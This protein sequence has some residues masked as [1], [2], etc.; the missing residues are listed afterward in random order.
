MSYVGLAVDP[1]YREAPEDA[2]RRGAF[3]SVVRAAGEPE[4]FEMVERDRDLVVSLETA[5]SGARIDLKRDGTVVSSTR[6]KELRLPSPAPGVYRVEVYLEDHPLLSDDVPWILSN[7]LFVGPT[8]TPVP[9]EA[10]ACDSVDS[11]ELDDS[12]PRNGRRVRGRD[13]AREHRSS[14]PYLQALGEDPGENRLM[15]RAR[16]SKADGPLSVSRGGGSGRLAGADAILDRGSE[17]ERLALCF[18]PSPRI[19]GDSLGALLPDARRETS[20]PPRHD[21]FA[22]RHG[23]Y[24]ELPHGLLVAADTGIPGFLPLTRCRG[25]TRC[26]LVRKRLPNIVHQLYRGL[27]LEL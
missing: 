6:E 22:F 10:V 14:N 12:R 13:R 20:H 1:R 8:R 3:F 25:R 11:V 5:T 19:H 26:S 15:G 7:P 9:R 16:P 27:L 23:E 21:R 18:G 24:F 17:R 4:R 2:I